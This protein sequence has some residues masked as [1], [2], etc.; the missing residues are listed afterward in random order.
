[1]DQQMTFAVFT[2]G[3]LV[4]SFFSAESSDWP[5]YDVISLIYVLVLSYLTIYSL[6]YSYPFYTVAYRFISINTYPH[7]IPMQNIGKCT[8]SDVISP[9]L[10]CFGVC[11]FVSLNV[12]ASQ[13]LISWSFVKWMSTLSG[14][15][16]FLFSFLTLI[17]LG[18]N[19]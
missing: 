19:S 15:T 16:T 2:V 7:E 4:V 12:I 6:S 11:R 13:F 17:S 8:I 10:L 14:K 18:V 1:M 3:C 9:F 5:S